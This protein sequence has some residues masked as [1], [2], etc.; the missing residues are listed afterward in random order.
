MAGSGET[1][2]DMIRLD[3]QLPGPRKAIP[4]EDHDLREDVPLSLLEEDLP[5]PDPVK[6]KEPDI[7]GLP[8]SNADHSQPSEGR[9]SLRGNVSVRA[10]GRFI[11]TDDG[12]MRLRFSEAFFSMSLEE[13]Y[14]GL[15]EFYG[16]KALETPPTDVEV[17]KETSR[18][19]FTMLVM[20]ALL[21][22]LKRGERLEK[23]ADVVLSMDDI[24]GADDSIFS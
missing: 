23:D 11:Y 13:Q 9:S 2:W 12:G 3:G 8:P 22:K 1:F 24:M 14:R 17:N 6:H 5:L 7:P 10:T 18:H 21:N 16:K 20:E 4:V 15:A 19:E